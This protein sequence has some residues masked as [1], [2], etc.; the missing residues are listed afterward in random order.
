MK[1]I[2]GL[3]IL[4]TATAWSTMIAVGILHSVGALSWTLSYD[5]AVGLSAVL[6]VPVL[7]LLGVFITAVGKA[8]EGPG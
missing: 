5:E 4:L 1:T 7:L 8:Q 6:L 2:T 3:A